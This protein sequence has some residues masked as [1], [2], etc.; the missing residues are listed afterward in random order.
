MAG[1]Y[2]SIQH[3][4]AWLSTG[5][6]TLV[7]VMHINQSVNQSFIVI[8]LYQQSST[9]NIGLCFSRINN[10][11][12]MN[13]TIYKDNN[14]K[15]N[16]WQWLW[17]RTH[18]VHPCTCSRSAVQQS[19]SLRKEAVGKCVSLAFLTPDVFSW[20]EQFKDC[21]ERVGGVPDDVQCPAPAV[22]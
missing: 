2:N 7:D 17:L 4:I 1:S 11:N 20:W 3:S 10:T 12:T 13:N 8:L 15:L 18:E 19:N 16:V 14:L 6:F 5:P 9:T 22:A 21:E